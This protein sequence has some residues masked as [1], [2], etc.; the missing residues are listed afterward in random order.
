MSTKWDWSNAAMVSRHDTDTSRNVTVGGSTK[1]RR[2]LKLCTGIGRFVYQLFPLAQSHLFCFECSSGLVP[3]YKMTKLIQ[4]RLSTSLK[5]AAAMTL[6]GLYGIENH[7]LQPSLAALTI[8]FLAGGAVSGINV[9]T[10]INRAAGMFLLCFFVY[11]PS[12]SIIL[13]AYFFAL[14]SLFLC[15]R[16]CRGWGVLNHGCVLDCKFNF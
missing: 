16:N 13:Y 2:F 1:Q 14:L 5:V 15:C 11:L 9:M 8:A 6:A 12:E 7:R 3:K 10:C 4:Q